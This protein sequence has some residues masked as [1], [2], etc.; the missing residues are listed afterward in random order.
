MSVVLRRAQAASGMVIGTGASS[1]SGLRPS[2]VLEPSTE[3]SIANLITF[4]LMGGEFPQAFC[5][6]CRTCHN[7]PVWYCMA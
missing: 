4:Y 6:V 2:A 5:P 7:Q 1:G 3:L